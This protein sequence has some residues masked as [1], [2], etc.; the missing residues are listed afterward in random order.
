MENA[1]GLDLCYGTLSELFVLTR[2]LLIGRRPKTLRIPTKWKI[3]IT[4]VGM[5]G[6]DV[7]RVMV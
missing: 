1:F 7:F 2:G 3:S 6:L 5:G 4:G